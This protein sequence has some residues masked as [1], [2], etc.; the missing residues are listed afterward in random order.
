MAESPKAKPEGSQGELS[1]S[2]EQRGPGNVVDGEELGEEDFGVEDVQGG[3]RTVEG[4]DISDQEGQASTIPPPSSADEILEAIG[5]AYDALASSQLGVQDTRR[6]SRRGRRKHRKERRSRSQKY[7][8]SSS[9]ESM[10]DFVVETSRRNILRDPL[11]E[12]V[13]TSF[14]S[15]TGEVP[16]EPPEKGNSCPEQKQQSTGDVEEVSV[17]CYMLNDLVQFLEAGKEEEGDALNDDTTSEE[18]ASMQNAGR[19]ECP[20][21]PLIQFSGSTS[22]GSNGPALA[23]P[24]NEK[25]RLRLSTDFENQESST[26]MYLHGSTTAFPCWHDLLVP[27]EM[28]NEYIQTDW[29]RDESSFSEFAVHAAKRSSTKVI[30]SVCPLRNESS[31]EGSSAEEL[32]KIFA[33]YLDNKNDELSRA[34]VKGMV[35]DKTFKGVSSTDGALLVGETHWDL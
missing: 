18:F 11:Y 8:R 32:H 4:S 19:K 22:E 27:I 7:S 28:V 31:G 3:K 35:N 25:F 17:L 23:E 33:G 21:V 34:D 16:E 14:P 20:D 5:N 6:A 10:E 30:P 9:T 2:E 13:G 29:C 24:R 15:T 1:V 12:V 26:G